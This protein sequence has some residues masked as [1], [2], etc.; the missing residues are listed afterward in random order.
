M[1]F[2]SKSHAIDRENKCPVQ[3]NISFSIIKILK[4]KRFRYSNLNHPTIRQLCV[5]LLSTKLFEVR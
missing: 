2:Q 1:K 5:R 4:I 3:A